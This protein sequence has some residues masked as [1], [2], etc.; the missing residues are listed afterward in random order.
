MVGSDGPNI[1]HR[2]RC[3]GG[4]GG[5]GKAPEMGGSAAPTTFTLSGSNVEMKP[6]RGGGSLACPGPPLVVLLS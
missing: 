5:T 1:A 3:F 2:W 6:A 4:S